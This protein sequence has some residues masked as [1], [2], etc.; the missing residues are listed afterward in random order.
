M[1]MKKVLS[2]LLTGVLTAGMLAGCA[3]SSGSGAAAGS[4]PAAGTEAAADA[5]QSAAKITIARQN[6]LAYI[7]V[8]LMEKQGLVNKYYENAEV[9]FTTLNS[10]AAIN[11]GLISGDIQ[12]GGSGLGPAVTAVM[13]GIPVKIASGVSC[14]PHKLMTSKEDIKTLADIGDRKIAL[15]NIGSIQHVI[16]AMG[17]KEQLGDAHALDNN[18]VAMGHPDGMAALM[19]GSVDCHL[20]TAP[21]LNQ[22]LEDPSMHEVEGISDAWPEDNSFIVLLG[23]TALH[24]E[25]PELFNAVLS[26]LDEA[27]TFIEENPDKTAEMVC[28]EFDLDAATLQGYI[29]ADSC[30]YSTECGGV[31]KFATF[32]AENDFLDG[33]APASFAD[34][35][36]DNVKGD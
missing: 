36:F 7:P 1:N 30:K 16:L 14:Q 13:K 33:E 11:D 32:M 2:V 35:A 25:N 15:V 9:T 34:L 5:Q 18:I 23:S 20:T 4:A 10:G 6:G 26:A 3:G 22:E 17:A 29:E 19:S 12:F 8:M 21:Y 31:M 24:D 27:I 28:S